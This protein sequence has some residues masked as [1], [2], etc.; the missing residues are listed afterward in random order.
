MLP[1]HCGICNQIR[2]CAVLNIS[3]VV[4]RG[5]HP[6][7]FVINLH[8][9]PHMKLA[10]GLRYLIIPLYEHAGDAE[11]VKNGLY[12]SRIALAQALSLYKG[13]V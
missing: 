1:H 8:T 6:V 11:T 10:L 2:V 3:P 5:I 12:R 9:V 4:G 7:P 13:S